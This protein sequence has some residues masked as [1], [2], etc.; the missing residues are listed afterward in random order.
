MIIGMQYNLQ[1]KGVLE[2]A[3]FGSVSSSEAKWKRKQGSCA[4]D[5]PISVLDTRSPSPST[6]ASTLS[7]SLGGGGSN[8]TD[9]TTSLAAVSDNSPFH[10]WPVSMPPEIGPAAVTDSDGGGRKDEWVWE[11]Q[12]VPGELEVYRGERFGVGL[13]DWDGFLPE[14]AQDQSS[15]RWIA[16]EIETSG[17]VAL[18]VFDKGSTFGNASDFQSHIIGSYIDNPFPGF[19]ICQQQLPENPDEKPQIFNP[20]VFI[21]QPPP[22]QITPTTQNSFPPLL[23]PQQDPL[24]LLQSPPNHQISAFVDLPKGPFIDSGHEFLLGKQQIQA[25]PPRHLQQKPLMVPKQKFSSEKTA[26][27]PHYHQ[28]Q[29]VYDHLYTAAELILAGDFA[30]AQGIL[31]RLNHQLS[32]FSKPFQRA[33]FYF[34]EALHLPLP[35]LP[36]RT[37]SPF[38]AMFKMSAYKLLSEVSPFTQFVNFT[39]NQALLEALHG[40]D[41]VH[42]VDFDIGF[43]AQ[44]ASFMQE[45][46]VKKRGGATTPPTYLKI[47]A[48][49]SP[50]THH[51]LE[52]GLM[53][54]NLTQFATEMGIHFE[55]EVVNFDDFDPTSYWTPPPAAP[56]PVIAVNFPIWAFSSRPAVLP[57]LLQ[58]V[59]L[60]SPKI[61]IS[62]ER[63]CERVDL[64]FSHHLLH[65]LQYYESLLDSLEA[66]NPTSETMNKIE[67]FLFRPLIE[68]IVLGRLNSPKHMPHW[69][70]LFASAGFSQVSFSNFT[71]TQA[72]CILKRSQVRGFHV[73]KHEGS[74]V[75][76]WQHRVLVC[77][78]AWSC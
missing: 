50:S 66:A 48:F 29:V 20:H 26:A 25:L 61:I 52:L 62:L 13:E 58:F 46:P 41:R 23:Y 24:C 42:I 18:G 15:I 68:S 54:E 70:S 32:P 53:H 36:A 34:K 44:W 17:N 6:S 16:G 75:L 65:T 45:L 33:A 78:S 73:G 27:Q 1:D 51:P 37:P 76:Y 2:V 31:A 5:E 30:H 39:S 60:L 59:K 71:E 38:D 55:L 49:A 72:Q 43:G 4:S 67:R 69:K 63:G 21:N 57:S 7:S 3:G 35:L 64:R 11:L 40:A 12:P 8:S 19:V 77:A 14:S 74:L 47:T 56:P 9:I 22:S 28:Q 10:K